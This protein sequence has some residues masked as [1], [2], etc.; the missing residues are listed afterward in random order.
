[1]KSVS[2]LKNSLILLLFVSICS[3]AY[4][5]VSFA[6]SASAPSAPLSLWYRAPATDWMTQALPLGNGR[7]GAMVFGGVA[8]EHIQF[9]DKTL[10]K[11]S[12]T[13]RGSY[14]NFGDLFLDFQGLTAVSNYRRD[15]SLSEAISRVSYTV[16]ATTYTR[17]YFCSYPD[18]ALVLRL[19]SN[20]SGNLSFVV[21]LVDAHAGTTTAA[22]NTITMSGALDLLSYEAQLKVVN[23]GGSLSISGNQITVTNANAV[24]LI[25]AGG[26]DYS[27]TAANYL[28]GTGAAGLHAATAEQL[29][30]SS[31][32]TYATLKGNHLRDYQPLFDRVALNL[33][34]STPT[35]PT[36]ELLASFKGKNYNTALEVLY[37]QYARFFALSS[38]R[39]V[40][41]PSNLQGL[42]NNSNTP[43]WQCD[44][45]NNINVE[46]NYWL[47]EKLNL[48]ETHLPF[49]NYI[50]NEA[51]T[52]ASWKHQAAAIGCNGWAM[53]TQNNIFGFT[54]WKQD[55]P[56]NA[57]Y[58]MHL[59][60]HY[61]FTLDQ[62]YL[63]STAYP[64]MKSAC[65]FWLSRL[66]TGTDGTLVAPAEWS[67]E[68]STPGAEDG[69]S[70]A[71]QLIWDLFTNTIQASTILNV[72]TAYRT[73]LQ[74]KL[75]KLDPGTHIGSWGELREWKVT[76]DRQGDTHRHISPLIGLY[77]GSQISPLL[78][79]KIA[80][81][82]KVLLISRGDGS[83]GWSCA[84]RAACWARLFDGNHALQCLRVNLLGG[85]NTVA[86][87]FDLYPPFQ[88][89]ANFGGPAAMTEMLI[90]SQLDTLQL[91]PALPDA[92]SAGT[93]VGLR[94]KGGFE[95][96]LS[97]KAKA[98]AQ[99]TLRSKSGGVCVVKNPLFTS[100]F[101][102][103]NALTNGAVAYTRNNDTITFS[104][105]AGVAYL[106]TPGAGPVG[107]GTAISIMP[108][109][110]S[111][112]KGATDSGS[113]Y[114][115]QL[116]TDLTNAGITF[117]F[118]GAATTNTS[119]QLLNAGQQY[120]NGFGSFR[121]DSIRVNLDGIT[122][123]AGDNN[124]GGFWLT[125]GNTTGP[126]LNRAPVFPDIVLIHA[127]T[128]DVGQNTALA[129]M[130]TRLTDLLN[131]FKTNRPQAEIFVG[132]IVPWSDAV[133]GTT[134][135]NAKVKA[136]NSWLATAVPTLGSH[137]HV[138]DLYSLFVDSA[139]LLKTGWLSD[140]IHPAHVGYVAM[141]DAW[142]QAIK[143][144][145]NVPIN[146]AKTYKIVIKLSGKVVEVPGASTANGTQ[147]D[148]ATDT[149]ASNQRWTVTDVG[150]GYSALRN[151]RS[152][153]AIDLAG[154]NPANAAAIVQ[155][156]YT[157]A[158]N[159]QWQL[160][161]TG[162]GYFKIVSRSSGKVFDVTA[163]N[164]ADG[165]LIQQWPD[166]GGANQRFQ[167]IAE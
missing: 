163:N 146:P 124:Q 127:G 30:S 137:F 116:F 86:N 99:A 4:S 76:P 164:K 74:A 148:Q 62:A 139:G 77:P 60:E 115:D 96:G 43:A 118:V 45:H 114:R 38:S 105:T 150:G 49:L 78:D 142:F 16:G 152:G 18:H 155:W 64:V 160:V 28:V 34:H 89:D 104:T 52:H 91:L 75:A 83:F 121:T 157:S 3:A 42:W 161:D 133:K 100:A 79:P 55:R 46:M 31:S 119:N 61:T 27:A 134:G 94:A 92:W 25:L 158:V 29:S 40:A 71:Q 66:I 111:I 144:Y 84:W 5:E 108:L 149:G 98:L 97:W 126:Q 57:W 156:P 128:N 129:T 33:N 72:D 54:D 13:S 162:G 69:V 135:F 151:K 122:Q 35:V 17:E 138:V 123:P 12:P 20:G 87:L 1:M 131:W 32:K 107:G 44:I 63:A 70:Y 112:T 47:A 120:H 81:A 132:Q 56:A 154:A 113:G 26:T 11:G 141:G 159:Q 167:L 68:Q 90:Q 22:G 125:G 82:A 140:G 136:Y 14:Q 10:W 153:L 145:L 85:P 110:D 73:T 130:Q 37:F 80:D 36:D 59:W 67:P 48:S 24:T 7:L 103:V 9:N 166:N 8:T 19:A 41:L 58:C 15:L 95:V 106:I 39:G 102:L 21:R 23:E 6:G 65:D 109:G 93:V 117:K 2:F 88:I 165:T 53:N 51:L 50:Y 143:S 147:L 101:T